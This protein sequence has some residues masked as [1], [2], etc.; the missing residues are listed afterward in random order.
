MTHLYK[1]EDDFTFKRLLERSILNREK[2]VVKHDRKNK[3]GN[4]AYM[5][6]YNM[7]V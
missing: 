1:I 2:N 4:N 5:A 7:Y 3:Y 6:I